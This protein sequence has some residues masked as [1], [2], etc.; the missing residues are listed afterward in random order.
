[1]FFNTKS[2]VTVTQLNQIFQL[3]PMELPASMQDLCL[4]DPCMFVESLRLD[5]PLFGPVVTEGLQPTEI[6]ITGK[7]GVGAHILLECLGHGTW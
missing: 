3:T 2:P 1:M 7:D 5:M 6:D 4:Q